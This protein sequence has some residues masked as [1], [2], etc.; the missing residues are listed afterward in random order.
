MGPRCRSRPLPRVRAGHELESHPPRAIRASNPC[1]ARL[2][3]LNSGPAT[4]QPPYPNPATAAASKL[5]KLAAE[6]RAEV[7]SSSQRVPTSVSVLPSFGFVLR[8]RRNSHFSFSCFLCVANPRRTLQ[9]LAVRRLP[10]RARVGRPRLQSWPPVSSHQASKR[11]CTFGSLSSAPSG[12]IEQLRP[13]P[14]MAPPRALPAPA[15]QPP[16]LPT[17]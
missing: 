11:S 6:I 4:P 15:G 16:S 7:I 3:S 14:A 8:S 10:S 5:A 17:I 2:P 13:S 12:S 1:S 9:R